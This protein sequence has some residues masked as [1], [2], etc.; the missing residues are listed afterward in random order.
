M[1][2]Y[3]KRIRDKCMLGMTLY[4]ARDGYCYS[5]H[6]WCIFRRRNGTTLLL[7]YFDVKYAANNNYFHSHEK[8]HVKQVFSSPSH[9]LYISI[10]LA[11]RKTKRNKLLYKM[12]NL[13]KHKMINLIKNVW[14]HFRIV[15]GHF[16]TNVMAL[17]HYYID[18][19]VSTC[20]EIAI[21]KITAFHF[22]SFIKNTHIH[23][24]V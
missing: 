16:T 23:M 17:W 11:R 3:P 2:F 18:I 24:T 10:W 14:L 1:Y 9:I 7:R 21:Y 19:H 5:V 8:D 20:H 15:E 22:T 12:W 4:M 6:R 13:A